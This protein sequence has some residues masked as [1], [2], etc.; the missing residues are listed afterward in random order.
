MKKFHKSCNRDVMCYLCLQRSS[1]HQP[2]GRNDHH[3]QIYYDTLNPRNS[4]GSFTSLIQFGG[5]KTGFNNNNVTSLPPMHRTHM[6]RSTPMLP[7]ASQNGGR[8]K[9]RIHQYYNNNNSKEHDQENTKCS[10]YLK[11]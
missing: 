10:V 2:H 5:N 7:V 4:F 3:H 8:Q 6:G 1:N 11:N 9:F